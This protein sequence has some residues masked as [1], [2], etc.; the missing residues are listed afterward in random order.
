[1]E[2]QRLRAVTEWHAGVEIQR[3][4]RGSRGRVVAHCRAATVAFARLTAEAY[5]DPARFA[6]ANLHAFN[7]HR[8]FLGGAG[9]DAR[10]LLAVAKADGKGKEEAA[11]TA[12]KVFGSRTKRNKE[13]SNLWLRLSQTMDGWGSMA[14]GVAG[15]SEV[16]VRVY[17][18]R[19]YSY[20][21]GM[22]STT[23]RDL[24]VE[25]STLQTGATDEP[26]HT[27][28]GLQD[29]ALTPWIERES[30]DFDER[31]CRAGY[32]R[33]GG[34]EKVVNGDPPLTLKLELISIENGGCGL[35]SSHKMTR[36]GKTNPALTKVGNDDYSFLAAEGNDDTN[37][38]RKLRRSDSGT[39]SGDSNNGSKETASTHSNSSNTSD[40]GS[41]SGSN[42]DSSS[43]G[44]GIATTNDGDTADKDGAR[45]PI[46][47]QNN[48]SHPGNGKY[49]CGV[50][51]CGEAVGVTRALPTGLPVPRWEG[52]VFYLPL[53]AAAYRSGCSPLAEEAVSK[54]TK[55]DGNHLRPSSS[56]RLLQDDLPHEHGYCGR[57]ESAQSRPPLLTVTLNTLSLESDEDGSTR[58]ERDRCWQT[59][60]RA[61]PT[62]EKSVWS[63]FLSGR[64]E[65]VPVGR[66]VL[67]A[68]DVLSMLGSQQ[69]RRMVYIH[70]THQNQVCIV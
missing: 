62:K 27:R 7:A 66:A 36:E 29:V 46:R 6:A 24:T 19:C 44:T 17:L 69:V 28:R 20:L 26:S 38:H 40:S 9:I 70:R 12:R 67:E 52:Q 23:G 64:I 1:M 56:Q 4:W 18:R 61:P 54:E 33:D 21:G 32:H 39:S 59:S 30:N 8:G 63:A 37:G 47:R 50:H 34:C 2:R 51:W 45:R 53:C 10:S 57:G 13:C 15:I 22:A 58:E 41:G 16:G 65:P 14:P 68:G 42:S 35:S 48:T 25:Q 11:Q 3:L 5:A 31:E 49:H 43:G 60:I 55:R